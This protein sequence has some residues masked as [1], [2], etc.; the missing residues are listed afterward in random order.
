[1]TREDEQ[2]L[3]D[4]FARAW[5]GKPKPKAA[6]LGEAGLSLLYAYRQEC[7]ANDALR[8]EL[9]THHRGAVA[10]ERALRRKLKRAIGPKAA[11]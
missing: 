6:E 8:T 10:I 7:A 9:E 4:L 11:A 3:E 5:K 1:M 2:R